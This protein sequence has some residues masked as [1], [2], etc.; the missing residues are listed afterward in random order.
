MTNTFLDLL[1]SSPEQAYYTSL[2]SE[3]ASIFTTEQDWADANSL[4]KLPIGD[5]I[6]R[7]SLRRNPILTKMMLREVMSK[8]GLDLPDGYH[9]PRGAWLGVPAVPV[10]H[11]ER[12]YSNPQI[13]DPFRFVEKVPMGVREGTTATETRTRRLQGISTTSDTFLGFGHGRHSWYVEQRP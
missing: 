6:I 4:A 8:G 13:Y 12:F 3:A 9:L 7:E 10:H 5:S 1:S 2:R 11:D